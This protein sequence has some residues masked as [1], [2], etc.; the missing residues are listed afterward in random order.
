MWEWPQEVDG[1]PAGAAAATGSP[2]GRRGR[3]TELMGEQ[4]L[5]A[6]TRDS[7]LVLGE[8]L[9]TNWA[10]QQFAEGSDNICLLRENLQNQR[11][12]M[13]FCPDSRKF[14]PNGKLISCPRVS[15]SG[16]SAPQHVGLPGALSCVK[17][18]E[19]HTGGAPA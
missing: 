3:C 5:L 6:P 9:D 7:V 19:R 17:V 8:R 11:D 13:E 18:P 2:S 4:L 14:C 10:R 15:C 1:F 16:Q 12:L